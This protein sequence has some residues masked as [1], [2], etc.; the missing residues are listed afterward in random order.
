VNPF[1]YAF[2]IHKKKLVEAVT[3]R[4]ASLTAGLPSIRVKAEE[5]VWPAPPAARSFS[6]TLTPIE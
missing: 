3:L 4:A 5:K 2:E 1:I 6:S